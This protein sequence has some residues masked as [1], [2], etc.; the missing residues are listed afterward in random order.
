MT[1]TFPETLIKILAE[2]QPSQQGL[3]Y[4]DCIPCWGIRHPQKECFEYDT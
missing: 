3:E 4:D 2:N 1:Q